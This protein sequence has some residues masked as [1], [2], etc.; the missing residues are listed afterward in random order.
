MKKFIFVIVLTAISM[1]GFT[2]ETQQT[3]QNNSRNS[4]AVHYSTVYQR[5]IRYN[6]FNVAKGALYNLVNL[7]PANDSLL[8][9]LSILYFQMQQY[10]SAALSA[11]DVLSLNPDH[12]GAME[13]SAVSF[14][15]IGA[16]EK[17]LESYEKLFLNTNNFQTLYQMAFLQYDLGRL[18]ESLTNV[19]ILLDKKEASDLTVT[20]TTANNQEKE[21]PIKA[22]LYNLKGLILQAQGNNEQ[23]KKL[24]NQALAIAPDFPL[25]KENLQKLEK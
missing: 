4:A 22:A 9:S 3:P 13:I 18:N 17:A 8:Y 5:A 2:Q 12:T 1:T 21:Y 15:N 23:A 19:D 10:A 6:D 16:K 7:Y 14:E 25:A 24:Y 20:Y 11:R